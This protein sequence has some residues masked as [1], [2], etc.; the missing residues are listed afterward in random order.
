MPRVYR[1]VRADLET[2]THPNQSGKNPNLVNHVQNMISS[3]NISTYKS[4]IIGRLRFNKL[5]YRQR[6]SSLGNQVIEMWIVSLGGYTRP[7]NN[8]QQRVRLSSFI[9]GPP[10][11]PPVGPPVG[12]QHS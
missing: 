1:K 5:T 6:Y 2:S 10:W 12:R 7:T 4:N 8:G 11:T 9:P 3:H